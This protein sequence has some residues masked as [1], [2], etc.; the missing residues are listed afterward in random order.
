MTG[1][2]SARSTRLSISRKGIGE[3]LSFLSDQP[4]SLGAPLRLA[5]RTPEV[6]SR[7]KERPGDSWDTPIALL[8]ECQAISRRS[9]GPGTPGGSGMFVVDRG[10][11]RVAIIALPAPHPMNDRVPGLIPGND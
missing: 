1:P 6:D 11:P 3:H 4:I 8:E 9:G 10:G 2:E 5:R 7:G